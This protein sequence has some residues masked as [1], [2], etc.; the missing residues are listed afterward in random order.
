[1]QV[2]L[3]E[4]VE[5]LGQMGDV[6]TVKPG[7]A[8]N[9]LLPQGKALRATK[10]NTARF[11]RER[12]QLEARNLELRKE[13][14]AVAGKL[15]GQAFIVI[16]QAGDSGQLYGSV[17]ARDVSEA[18]TEGGFSVDRGQIILDRPIKAIGMHD[19]R[20]RLHPE[21]TVTVQ[22]NVARTRDEA[23]LQAMGEDVIARDRALERAEEDA[24][25]AEIL[26]EQAAAQEEEGEY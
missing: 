20:V 25:T 12:A 1:M 26:E 6:V 10:D 4:R 22:V 24:A 21:V 8:R 14:E 11:E 17:S 7:F 23:E 9:F 3:L 2:I 18:A 19:V 5:K 15:D 13:A 16:R